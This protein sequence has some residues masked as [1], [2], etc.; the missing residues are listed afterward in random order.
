MSLASQSSSTAERPPDGSPPSACVRIVSANVTS[1]RPHLHGLI[2]WIGGEE[3]SE[4]VDAIMLQ[5]HAV[6]E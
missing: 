2:Q 1:L 4:A 3:S 6:L 5:E